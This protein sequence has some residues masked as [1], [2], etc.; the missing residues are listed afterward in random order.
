M[1]QEIIKEV[2]S[3][4]STNKV[5]EA[6]VPSNIKEFA[7]RNGA[8]ALVNKV[9]GWAE[10]CGKGIRGGTAIGK[11]YSTLVLDLG[12]QDGAIHINLDDQT[13]D[14]YG[15]EV[16]DV[17]SFKMVLDNNA[18][19][20]EEAAPAK[21]PIVIVMV[22]APSPTGCGFEIFGSTFGCSTVVTVLTGFVSM[23]NDA[24]IRAAGGAG[25][26]EAFSAGASLSPKKEIESKSCLSEYF[27]NSVRSVT[28]N[29]VPS[30]KVT[31]AFCS[32]MLSYLYGELIFLNTFI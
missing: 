9:A 1:I 21:A 19:E 30:F 16:F 26:T 4:R 24:L 11:N 3:E 14:L 29:F 27:D 12:Y 18:N 25:I 31:N 10:K 8:S 32:A 7:K 6:Y 2:L 28:S 20:I 15:E 22:V 23:V 17:K 5:N 13:V